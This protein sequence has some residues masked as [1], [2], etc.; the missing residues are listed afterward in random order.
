[1]KLAIVVP[2]YNEQEVLPAT[3]TRLLELLTQL[4]A[5]GALT[6]DSHLLFVDDGSGDQT[7][8]LLQ[9]AAASDP[10]V[11]ALRLSRNCGHQ[12]ALLAGLH[13]ARGDAVVS[14]DAD[15]Q[16]DVE[17][18]AAMVQAARQGADIVYGV[19]R[20]RQAD[21]RFKRVTAEIY[22]RILA[23]FGVE[24]VFNHAD[25]RLMSRRALDAFAQFGESNLFLRG[26]VPQLGFTTTFVTY[27]RQE[28]NA[29]ES[30]YPLRR[31]LS[32]AWEGITSFSIVPLR[33][34]TLLGLVTCVLALGVGVWGLWLGLFTNHVVPGWTSTL[35]PITF[36]GGVQLLSLGVIGEYV[37]KIYVET[38]RRPPYFVAERLWADDDAA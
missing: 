1:M 21:T 34:I 11:R 28:R 8:A 10:R 29:G 2:C 27:D 38:K 30:K 20:Q 32:L 3:V 9:Q 24:I 7:W 35:V 17:A 36:I 6:A 26:L 15:L 25:F 4:H 22:Y 37:G 23:L 5:A 13:A 12:R 18:I 33:A 19:R 16:D 14:I 31:M